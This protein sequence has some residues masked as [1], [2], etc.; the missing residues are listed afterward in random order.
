MQIKQSNRLI[1]FLPVLDISKF[2]EFADNNLNVGQMVK[3]VF[4]R[5]ENIL[6]KGQNDGYQH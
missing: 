1:D 4:D 5:L 6:R 3:Y 2:K